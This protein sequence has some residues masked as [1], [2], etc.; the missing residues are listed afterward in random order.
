VNAQEVYERIRANC[1]EIHGLGARAG[2]PRNDPEALDRHAAAIA[3][4][5]IKAKVENPRKKRVA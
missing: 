5:V 4:E 1:C 3:A 2:I